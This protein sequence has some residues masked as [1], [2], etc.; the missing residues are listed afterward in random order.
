MTTS[1]DAF[2]SDTPQHRLECLIKS[3][4]V[5]PY[6]VN[7]ADKEHSQVRWCIYGAPDTN[8]LYVSVTNG[9]HQFVRAVH[10]A[11]F[12]PPMRDRIFG[13]DVC[14]LDLAGGLSSA[15]WRDFGPLLVRTGS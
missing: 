6:L 4:R 12:H 3:G 10:S 11:V 13:I 7:N 8:E 9:T 15:M 14:D 2:D 1:S 5:I